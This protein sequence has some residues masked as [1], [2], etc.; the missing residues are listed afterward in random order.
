MTEAVGRRRSLV[1][2]TRLGVR[3]GDR[4]LESEEVFGR[5]LQ[6]LRLASSRFVAGTPTI[7]GWIIE[8]DP[9][10]WS[11]L[12][13]LAAAGELGVPSATPLAISR[14]GSVDE[15]DDLRLVGLGSER[16]LILRLDSDD[17]YLVGAVEAALKISSGLADGV[18]LDFPHGM[19]LE[20]SS[21]R[22][23]R[24]SYVMQGPFFGATSTGVD[25]S[26]I[27]GEHVEARARA[28]ATVVVPGQSWVQTVHGS[29][30]ATGFDSVPRVRGFR[31]LRRAWA[32]RAPGR[33]LS[34]LPQFIVNAAVHRRVDSAVARA[35][36]APAAEW[37]R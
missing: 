7:A 25:L 3:F 34:E 31:Q 15:A 10:W 2:V 1:V 28:S 11:R 37:K 14:R 4:P 19:L 33:S 17:V 30:I 6:I 29:N 35:A 36:V 12:R 21:G 9:H 23:R 5:R 24:M 16:L 27:H 20:P 8:T 26:A 22:T 32:K 13:A 18:L